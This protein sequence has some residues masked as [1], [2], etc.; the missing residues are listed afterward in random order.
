MAG[1][2][3]VLYERISRNLEE[4]WPINFV[5]VGNRNWFE[6]SFEPGVVEKLSVIY[7]DEEV[8]DG[9]LA[10]IADFTA[11]MLVRYNGGKVSDKRIVH[12]S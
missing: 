9:E 5:V 2:K 11:D 3:S 7:A 8:T 12:S 6:T 1:K 4:Y 10:D